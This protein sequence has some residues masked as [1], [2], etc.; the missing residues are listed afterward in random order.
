MQEYVTEAIILHKEPVRD[1]DARYFFFTKRFGKVAGRATSTRKITSKLAGHLEPGILSQVRFVERH[2]TQIVDA[3]KTNKLN[4]SPLDLRLLNRMLHEGEADLE[5]WEAI[6]AERFS[7]PNILRILGWDPA[8][9]ICESC[10]RGAV[11]FYIPRQEFF[12]LT[13]ASK[14]RR[15]ELI[16]LGNA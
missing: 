11:Y 10:G 16:L 3:L 8:G 14:L 9:A 7:W 2:G 15:N 1:Y 5:L 4:V 6:I 12:C 13:C